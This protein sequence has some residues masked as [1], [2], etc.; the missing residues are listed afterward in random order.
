M[1]CFASEMGLDNYIV[2]RKPRTWSSF[3]FEQMLPRKISWIIHVKNVEVIMRFSCLL[4]RKLLG[5]IWFMVSTLPMLRQLYFS[6][7]LSI[8]GVDTRI[9][10]R[11]LTSIGKGFRSRGK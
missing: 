7:C 9:T 8:G 2:S 1:K 6:I 4:I 11:S 5:L 3:T 10:L